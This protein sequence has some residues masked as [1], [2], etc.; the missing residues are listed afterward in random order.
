MNILKKRSTAFI[1]LA[2]VFIVFSI[3][4]ANRSLASLSNTIE[5]MFYEGVNGET[6]INTY[7]ENRINAAKMITIVADNYPELKPQRDALYDSYNNLY[8]A[9][10]IG[11]KFSVNKKLQDD[12]SELYS[13]FINLD[14]ITDKHYED[15]LSYAST[16]NNTQDKI[17][18][19][20]YNN[21]VD[22]FDSII[23]SFPIL[24][25]KPL[26]FVNAPEHFS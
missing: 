7:L 3:L 11:E 10:T 13:S 5:N 8:S 26:I 17:A 21:E 23:S 19:S 22:K 1:I 18:R 12:F 16:I 25:L 14:I 15:I 24:L 4:G 9:N 6:P 2:I 20:S